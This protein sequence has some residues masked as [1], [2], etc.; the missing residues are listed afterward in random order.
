M[1]IKSIIAL[2]AMSISA[3]SQNFQ[4]ITRVK[5]EQGKISGYNSQNKL[6]VQV[7]CGDM[8][9]QV[10]PDNSVKIWDDIHSFTVFPGTLL[11]PSFSDIDDS[12]R[13][14]QI[15]CNGAASSIVF[16]ANLDISSIDTSL[17]LPTLI[18]NFSD[19]SNDTLS[20]IL[21]ALNNLTPN[22]TSNL[23]MLDSINYKL[24]LLD[25]SDV[26]TS[27]V[28][29]DILTNFATKNNDTLSAILY[30]LNNSTGAD[31]SN[32]WILDSI[33]Q[34]LKSVDTL[35]I[36][37]EIGVKDSLLRTTVVD[38]NGSNAINVR[39]CS[40]VNV[41]IVSGLQPIIDNQTN[42]NQITRIYDSNT[43]Q[44]GTIVAGATNATNSNTA[45]VV[46]ERPQQA[47]FGA[48]GDT[49]TL[50]NSGV[51]TI[52]TNGALEII[53]ENTGTTN[54]TVSYQGITIPLNYNQQRVFK[55]IWDEAKR[56][57][58]PIGGLTVTGTVTAPIIVTRKFP[59]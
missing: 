24:G 3:F 48:I 20:A 55:A 19:R 57:Y 40:D 53:V 17:V 27:L 34:E 2:M 37:G 46:T 6:A 47:Q 16:P 21:A 59:Q 7:H 26:D 18:S 12:L 45:I 9:W 42:G 35:C 51:N 14:W 23:W 28:L 29:P 50:H 10:L 5:Y 52:P 15:S 41:N 13:I 54:T 32:F 36:T 44:V 33:L 30:A 11:V 1:R 4:T 39:I 56:L 8:V 49:V 25:K 22:D 31:T 58:S 43:G 38:C